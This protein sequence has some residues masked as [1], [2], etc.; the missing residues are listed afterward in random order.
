MPAASEPPEVSRLRR[1]ELASVDAPA[2][3]VAYL[4]DPA[5]VDLAGGELDIRDAT[6][7]ARA[8]LDT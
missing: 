5:A 2:R 6:L 7:R 1:E 3:A 4:C 8:G